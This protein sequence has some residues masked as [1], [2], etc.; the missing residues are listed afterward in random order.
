MRDADA[1][2]ARSHDADG[3]DLHGGRSPAA[4]LRGPAHIALRRKPY[5]RRAATASAALTPARTRR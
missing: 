2:L 5:A 4:T 1:H 3:P